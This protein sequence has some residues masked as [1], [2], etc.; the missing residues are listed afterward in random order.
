M[1]ISGGSFVVIL[2][3]GKIIPEIFL[4]SGKNA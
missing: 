4:Y 2:N 1:I 3:E